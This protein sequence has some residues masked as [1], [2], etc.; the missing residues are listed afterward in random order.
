MASSSQARSGVRPLALLLPVLG[1]CSCVAGCSDPT[2]PVRAAAVPERVTAAPLSPL[3]GEVARRIALPPRTWSASG[4]HLAKG[5]TTRAAG[6]TSVQG[7]RADC[8]NINLNKKLAADFRADVFGPGVKGFFYRCLRVAPGTNK[9]WFTVSSADRTQI[10]TLCD[11][12]TAYP[13]GY[14]EQHRTYWIDEPFTCT[15]RY[16]PPEPAPAPAGG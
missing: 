15:D 10:D 1:L 6:T 8:E 5:Y 12:A 9:Y 4:T 16:R 11:P 3:L 14:D 2:G 7:M 13:V